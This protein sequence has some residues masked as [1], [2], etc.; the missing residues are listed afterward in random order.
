MKL[1]YIIIVNNINC[2]MSEL[3]K[4]IISGQR[5]LFYVKLPWR[6]EPI[7]IRANFNDLPGGK[8]LR[9]KNVKCTDEEPMNNSGM[10]SMPLSWVVKI[11]TLEDII[12][13]DNFIAP[14][15]ILLEIDNYF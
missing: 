14:S 8:T 9:C 15:E 13:A 11:E 5:Y 6:N 2:K 3:F 4:N 12:G 10:L 7:P 1:N